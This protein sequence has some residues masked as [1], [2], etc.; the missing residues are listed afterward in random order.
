V[1]YFGEVS[2]QLQQLLQQGLVWQGQ[3]HQHHDQQQFFDSGWA[4]LNQHLGGGWLCGSVNEL[5][6]AQPFS[7][8]LALLVPLLR[9]LKRPSLWLN[10]PAQPYW[11]GLLHQQIQQPP[12]L[13]RTHSDEHAVWVLEQTMQSR[14]CGVLLAWLPKLPAAWVRRLQQCAEQHQQLVFIFSS[15]QASDEARAY[16]NRLQLQRPAD[17]PQQG[18]QVGIKKRR[19]GWPLPPFRCPVDELLPVRRRLFT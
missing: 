15:W 19:F 6:V 3:Q 10:P 5:Q 1:R 17:K 2:M 8:E 12:L 11:P 9:Q 4:E 18:L 14:Q 16:V 13:V 7:G